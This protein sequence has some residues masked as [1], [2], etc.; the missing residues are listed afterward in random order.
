MVEQPREPVFYP[1]DL[2]PGAFS[3]DDDTL[4]SINS[5]LERI[6]K[7]LIQMR[8]QFSASDGLVLSEHK[9]AAGGR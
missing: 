4:R 2:I 3:R 8:N 7:L 6:E 1:N 9:E 5:A